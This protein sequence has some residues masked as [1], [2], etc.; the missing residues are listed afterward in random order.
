MESMDALKKPGIMA[1]LRNSKG[2]SLIEMAIVLVII[3]IIIAAIIKGQ[4][5]MINSRAKQVI[6][7]ANAWKIA[8]FAYMDRNGVLPGATADAGGII[9]STTATSIKSIAETMAQAPQNPVVVGGQ[10]FYFYVTAAPG[11]TGA[12][13][14]IVICTNADC[15]QALT[16]DDAEILKT[17]DTSID[18]VADASAG[19]VRVLTSKTTVTAG[20]AANGRATAAPVILNSV[21]L[22][23]VW[24]T[25][26]IGAVWYFDKPY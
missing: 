9:D 24:N 3:G 2:F 11:S 13:N 19:Q 6:S 20:T 23:A 22:S 8:T 12:R 16:K 4:D 18:G 10:N 5:L 17:L 25:T 21:G 26:D 1:R 14:A 15:S 7:T